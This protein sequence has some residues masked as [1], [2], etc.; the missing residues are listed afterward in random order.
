MCGD[1]ERFEVGMI[2]R[3]LQDETCLMLQPLRCKDG[4]DAMKES[5]LRVTIIYFVLDVLMVK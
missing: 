1:H 3:Y 4:R 2:P 5:D